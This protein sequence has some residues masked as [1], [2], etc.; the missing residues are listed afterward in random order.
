[1]AS[2]L[3]LFHHVTVLVP[4][5]FKTR[6]RA[7]ISTIEGRPLTLECIVGG[8]PEPE[9][10]WFRNDEELPYERLS[11]IQGSWLTLNRAEHE[12]SGLYQCVVKNEA[13][14]LRHEFSVFVERK[15]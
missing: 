3:S 2:F 5:F 7:K 4:P 12:D 9:V 10:M 1:M 11:I 15:R 13:G 8:F 6:P 14:F